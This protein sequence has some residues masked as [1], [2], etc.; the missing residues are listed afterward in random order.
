MTHGNRGRLVV[1]LGGKWRHYTNTL[2]AGSRAIGTVTRDGYDTGALVRI[3]ATG[4]YVQCN[5]GAI[6]SLDQRKVVGA[7]KVARTGRG[8]PGRGGDRKTADG[9]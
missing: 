5:A 8:D 4:I 3:K 2:P 7:I 9:A 1:D 6:R